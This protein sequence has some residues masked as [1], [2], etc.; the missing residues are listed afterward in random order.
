MLLMYGALKESKDDYTENFV[1]S[2]L[3]MLQ[4]I[5][6]C[7]LTKSNSTL[8]VDFVLQC[9]GRIFPVEV[10]AET[11]LQAKS[12]KTLLGEYSELTG[13]RTS[14]A[15]YEQQQRIINVPLYAL[16]TFFFKTNT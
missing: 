7:Y 5:N 2:Q 16:K 12:L 15:D 3:S 4:D 14:M 13:I 10:K 11:N 9:N 1:C 6:L 8:E